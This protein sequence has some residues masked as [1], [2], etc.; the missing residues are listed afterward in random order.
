MR[1]LVRSR[2][3]PSRTVTATVTASHGAGRRSFI[4]DEP[5]DGAS[6]VPSMPACHTKWWGNRVKRVP[7]SG[8][9][10][11]SGA[12]GRA[13]ARA[14]ELEPFA[15]EPPPEAPWRWA[16]EVDSNAR[17]ARLLE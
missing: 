16:I 15:I 1:S 4:N 17:R 12:G 9:R 10:L 8:S 13:G 5:G 7:S 3:G 11:R 2:R 6:T 14:H